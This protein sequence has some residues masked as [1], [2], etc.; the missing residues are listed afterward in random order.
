M[1]DFVAIDFETA[2]PSRASVC[3]VGV[4]VVRD[5]EIVG[6]YYSLIKPTPNWYSWHNTQVHG[7]TAD[8]THNA[9]PF[10]EVWA[11]VDALVGDLPLVAHN[12]SFDEGCLKCAFEAHGMTYPDYEFLCTCQTS[13][14]VL[15]DALPDH[16]LPTVANY[17]GFN[18]ENHHNALADAMAC[19]QI[20]IKIL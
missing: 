15:G 20:A 10:P 16:R 8:D 2:N 14:N 19:A 17:V 11:E 6:N 1:K 4:I 9:R 13:R 7:I 12:K 3:S 18:L 5:G